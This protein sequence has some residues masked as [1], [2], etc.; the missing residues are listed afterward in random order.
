LRPLLER[1]TDA[2]LVLRSDGVVTYASPA[3]PAPALVYTFS[4]GESPHA[5]A[6][7]QL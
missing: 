7:G 6:G 3:T 1:S 4:R 5:D 2:A